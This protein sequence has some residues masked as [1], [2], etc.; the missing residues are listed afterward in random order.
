[1]RILLSAFACDPYLGSE[2]GVGWAWAYHLAKAG[3]EVCVLTRD[4]HRP[5]I[6]GKLRELEL[7]NLHFEYV[8]VR[9]VP[10]WM[11]GPGVYPYYFCWQWNAYF[12]A[13]RLHRECRF[14]VV[15]HVSY[16]V[17]RN[18]SYL[19]LLDAPFIFGPVGGGERS[20]RA[21]RRSMSRNGRRFEALRDLANLLPYFDPF[22]RSMV[23]HCARIVVKTEETRAYLPQKSM[24]RAVVSLENM[25]SEQPYLAGEIRRVLPLKLLYA[26]R[27]I[28]LKGIHLALQAIALL[29][30]QIPVKL[31]IV[32]K[33]PEEA[34]LKEEVAR[35]RLEQSVHF[36][37]WMPKTEVLALYSTH[38]ALLF[39]S[40]HDSSGTVVMEAIAHGKPVICLD[41]G[42]PAVTVDEHCARIVSTKGKTEKQVIQGMADAIME[43]A[44]MTSGDWEEMRR[45]AVSR[46]QFYAP[47]QVIARVY[48]PLLQPQISRAQNGT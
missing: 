24:E 32:G 40:L 34:R 7:P 14:D 31:T 41:L 13:R 17:F 5:V 12:R 25:L 42:G 35:L 21:L 48:G 19:Y 27:L 6:E 39:P 29:H 46:A 8:G 23:R 37:T 43:L 44:R 45:A 20:P 16:G 30:D 10:F 38:D 4:F 18:A 36:S 28:P 47:N 2:E 3:H 1:M 15:H 11:P 9:F 22:W 26:G 33:G